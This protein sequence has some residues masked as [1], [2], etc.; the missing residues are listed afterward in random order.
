M[1][2]EYVIQNSSAGQQ[3]EV[4][5]R[6]MYDTM[7]GSNDRAPFFVPG[8]GNSSLEQE[9]F[10][11]DMPTYWK[12]FESSSFAADSLK[13]QG[14]LKGNGAVT[15]NRFVIA[16]WS[17]LYN[18]TWDFSIDPNSATGD[19]AT[20]VYWEP[21]AVAAGG[22]ISFVTYYG[23][24]GPGGGSAWFDAVT[25]VTCDELE[26]E[27]TLWVNNTTDYTF[28]GGQ[29]TLNLPDG[30]TLAAGESATKSLPDVR[31]GESKSLT[32]RVVADGTR[33]STLVYS[34]DV[35][36]TS[37]HGAL[38]AEKAISVPACGTAYVVPNLRKSYYDGY[39][40][41]S[42]QWDAVNW[43][44]ADSSLSWT[45]YSVYGSAL[46][47]AEGKAPPRD[48]YEHSLASDDSVNNQFLGTTQIK[49]INPL[50]QVPIAPYAIW[51][52]TANYLGAASL[53]A[54]QQ[55]YVPIIAKQ[56]DLQTAFYIY[57][58]GNDETDIYITYYNDA[59]A[60][61]EMQED[62]IAANMQK[63][64]RQYWGDDFANGYRG[65]AAITADQPVVVVADM[66]SYLPE[67]TPTPRSKV[68]LPLILKRIN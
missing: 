41:F 32:W 38:Q 24:A 52:D 11:A 35:T 53:E 68:Y 31:T 54:A 18:S 1:R 27:T 7:I 45:L 8:L 62:N 22:Q 29:A 12:A 46:K 49:A 55:A 28:T 59:G 37:G 56:E 20:A 30:L 26:F 66:Y 61:T 43:Y 16:N 21:R 6:V 2:Y 44:E 17:R 4:G 3:Y 23:L 51:G 63:S 48:N 13:G 33:E 36:F 67:P 40:P 57:N 5:V 58:A 25:Q 10:S 19:S 47:S 15:P 60:P 14:I 34:A 9:F 50:A 39:G 65:A 42:S 64:Y